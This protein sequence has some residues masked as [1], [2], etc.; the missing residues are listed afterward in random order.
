MTWP[1]AFVEVVKMIGGAM[2]AIVFL[3]VVFKS[4]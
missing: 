4:L 3:I 1:E 2:V